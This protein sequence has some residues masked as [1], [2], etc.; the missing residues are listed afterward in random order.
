M[1]KVILIGNLTKDPELRTTQGGVSVCTL[2]IAVTR[3][4][5][6]AQGVRESDFFD[7]V[8]WRQTAD[9]VS[10]YFTKGRKIAITGTLQNR[11]YEAK[12]GTKRTVTEVIADE[13][14]FVDSRPQGER[15]EGG[16]SGGGYAEGGY[17]PQ[18]HRAE[19]SAND[20]T[21]QGFTQVDDDELPF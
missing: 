4:F 17:A 11:S 8:A 1:N 2:R 20:F 21:G 9:F 19:D 7:V 14:E 15:G 18:Q 16:Y 3:R 10:R 5:A 13:A 12:D 6:N